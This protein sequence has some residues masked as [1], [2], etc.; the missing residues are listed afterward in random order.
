MLLVLPEVWSEAPAFLLGFLLL[1]LVDRFIHPLCGDCS[2]DPSRWA[3][4]PLWLMLA[5]HSL[6]DGA[7][8]EMSRP[9]TL[10]AW[11]FQMH[12][13]PEVLAMVAL[14]RTAYPQMA[15]PG[16]GV[17]ALQTFVAAGFLLAARFDRSLLVQTYACAGGGLLFLALHRMHRSWVES[18]FSWMSS[19]AGAASVWV[20][21]LGLEFV[22]RH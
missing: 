7:L 20:V 21:R 15:Y 16:R 17:A 8:I 19:A 11:I 14:V 2:G 9:G 12:R 13:I 10:A 5:A 1:A 18:N 4:L 6:L 3:T 22:G